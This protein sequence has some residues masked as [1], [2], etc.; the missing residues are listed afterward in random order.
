MATITALNVRLGMD[1]SAFA[2]GANLARSEVTK[3]TSI[4]RQSEPAAQRYKKEVDLLNRAFSD[5]GKKTK[6]YANALEFLRKKYDQTKSTAIPVG[7]AIASNVKALAAS[8]IGLHTITKSIRLAIDAEQAA[9][10][11]DVLTGSIANSKSLLSQLRTLS[12][13]TP[14]TFGGV[15]DAAQTMLAFNVPLQD[16]MRNIQMLGDVSG[17]NEER[18]KSMTLAFAQ[19]NAAGRLMG[20]DVLQMINAGFNPLQQIA[21]KTGETMAELK[22]RMEAGGISS[23]EVTQA[24][25]DATS[26]GG[27]FNGMMDRL[28]D[29]TGGRLAIAMATLERAGIELG[30]TFGPLLTQ[31]TDGFEE[32]KSVIQ[33]IIFVIEKL[34]DGLAFTIAYWKDIAAIVAGDFGLKAS[35]KLLDDLD[36]R[37]RERQA[38]AMEG[39]GGFDTGAAGQAADANAVA[40]QAANQAAA[41]TT[42]EYQKQIETLRLRNI[43]LMH[44]EQVAERHRLLAKGFTAQQ[45]LEIEKLK[46]ASKQLEDQAKL[47]EESLEKARQQNEVFSQGVSMAM[48][49]AREHFAE[50]K[51]LDDKRREDASRG[52][53][54]GMEVGSA[55]AAKFMADQVNA[56]IGAAAV[57]PTPTPGEKEIA[58]KTREL[59]V[60]QLEANRKQEQQLEQQKML[61]AEFRDNKFMRTR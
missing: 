61:L 50:Q 54:A 43:E 45:I 23:A 39:R 34:N 24:F 21:A 42:N 58:D 14:L 4:M 27:R 5:A 49:A 15:Q 10:R 51:R 16:V 13:A 32:N 38:D 36:R 37:Q 22:K 8:Y 48:S 47:R 35:T 31:L 55:D 2:E 33:S 25:V 52:P 12:D 53:G 56:A 30:N 3:V 44:G 11:F 18:F 7:N 29:T 6:E 57:P 1:A 19:M 60:A 59:L 17:G 9:A 41:A 40:N 26:E 28:A 20:Q 46:H